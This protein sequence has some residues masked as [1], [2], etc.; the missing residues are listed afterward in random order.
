VIDTQA[1]KLYTKK[2][3]GAVI[4]RGVA[5]PVCISVNNVVCNH[6]P[7]PTEELVRV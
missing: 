5:F 1:Q 2:V 3:K 4:E 7:L 6:S